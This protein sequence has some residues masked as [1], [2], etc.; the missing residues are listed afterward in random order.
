M[1]SQKSRCYG[2]KTKIDA[3]KNPKQ[4]TSYKELLTIV[5][6]NPTNPPTPM[7]IA[8]AASSSY[9]VVVASNNKSE[10][11]NVT[12][13]M[14]ILLT[15]KAVRTRL[16]VATNSTWPMFL[17]NAYFLFRQTFVVTH[18]RRLV[19]F[20]K[21]ATKKEP[22]TK[23]KTT[24]NWIQ[25]PFL[26]NFL[27]TQTKRKKKKNFSFLG[28]TFSKNLLRLSWH[29]SFDMKFFS[30]FFLELLPLSVFTWHLV[31]RETTPCDNHQPTTPC[32]GHT[33]DNDWWLGCV[34]D[35]FAVM[36]TQHLEKKCLKKV[37]SVILDWFYLTH[38][39]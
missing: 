10:N 5:P 8:A 16:S 9:I 29:L 21:K 20:R 33:F 1:K 34:L 3:E 25:A 22:K 19:F 18:M 4:Q 31:Y 39:C 24:E 7:P 32:P 26:P 35:C 2:C 12:T 11:W 15:S 38:M 36:L 17:V 27:K 14:E 23:T 30:F 37:L 6:R 28:L 13:E